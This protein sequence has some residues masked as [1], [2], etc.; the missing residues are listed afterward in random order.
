MTRSVEELK[1]GATPHR[2]YFEMQ[3]GSRWFRGEFYH[4]GWRRAYTQALTKAA[5]KFKTSRAGWRLIEMRE[6]S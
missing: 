6:T 5:E 4:F 1:A 2:Y 3:K